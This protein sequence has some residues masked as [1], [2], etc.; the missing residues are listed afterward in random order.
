MNITKR[1]VREALSGKDADGPGSGITAGAVSQWVWT[2]SHCQKVASGRQWHFA[3]TC[4][5]QLPKG[6]RP[7]MAGLRAIDRVKVAMTDDWWS[8]NGPYTPITDRRHPRGLRL[9][10][11]GISAW[12]NKPTKA[13][14]AHKDARGW[15]NLTLGWLGRTTSHLPR[16]RA[17]CRLEKTQPAGLLVR[18]IDAAL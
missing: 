18:M 7:E 3:P 13:E 16:I 6:R 9:L 8:E 10:V 12:L 2:T 11:K 14:V 1:T 5:A 4:S 17:F 15:L